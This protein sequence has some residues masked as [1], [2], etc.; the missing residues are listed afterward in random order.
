M[1]GFSIGYQLH[2]DL[3]AT[4]LY[5]YWDVE[6]V[7]GT[8]DT[9]PV[10]MG[11]E[12]SNDFGYIEYLTGDNTKNRIG[13]VLNYFLSGVEFGAAADWFWGNYDPKFYVNDN[14]TRARLN[15]TG[16]FV[17]T[18]LGNISTDDVDLNQYRL[19]AFMKVSF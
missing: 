18:P 12:G 4:V 13:L 2:P 19:K 6:I 16:D 9:A 15:P 10:G 11:F 1:Y 3:Y 5:D 17:V 14:G 7:D 8:I